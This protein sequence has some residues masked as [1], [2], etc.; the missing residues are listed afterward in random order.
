MSSSVTCATTESKRQRRILG[1]HPLPHGVSAATPDRIGS[2]QLRIRL[3]LLAAVVALIVAAVWLAPGLDQVRARVRH[4]SLGWLVVASVLELLSALSYVVIF[5]SVFCPRMSWRMSYLIG[6][7]EQAANSILPAGG[8]GGLALG[9]WALRRVGAPAGHIA[10][11]TV[12]FFL[13]TS[14]ANVVTLILFALGVRRGDTRRRSSPGTDVRLRRCGGR[15][16]RRDARL[17]RCHHSP[18]HR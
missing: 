2:R 7:S 14:F 8:A 9:A 13:L 17:V 18:L 15:C 4:A 16:D 1:H 11:R 3:V 6:V 5:R 12:A 10:R